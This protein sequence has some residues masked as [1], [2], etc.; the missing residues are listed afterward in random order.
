MVASS[1]VDSITDRFRVASAIGAALRFIKSFVVPN[2]PAC[3]NL[4]I[5]ATIEAL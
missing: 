1:T 4:E 2:S 3:P 5:G